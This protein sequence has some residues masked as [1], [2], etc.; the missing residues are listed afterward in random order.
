MFDT[1]RRIVGMLRTNLS[2]AATN[3]DLDRRVEERTRELAVALE[4]ARSELSLRSE[5]E[6]ALRKNVTAMVQGRE[7]LA[8]AKAEAERANL[9]KSKFLASASHDL[10]QPVQ[11]LVLLISLV[12]KQV[13]AD[14]KATET[15]AMMKNALGRLNG[16]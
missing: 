14:A 3:K 10:R 16:S 9:A 15:V 7:A 2:L 5:A 12:E 6:D 8:S 13:R 4:T 11:S 1:R